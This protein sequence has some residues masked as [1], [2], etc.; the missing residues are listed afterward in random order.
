LLWRLPPFPRC[1]ILISVPSAAAFIIGIVTLNVATLQT[2]TPR[3]SSRPRV[4][5]QVA[6][7]QHLSADQR[8]LD[9]GLLE[10][11]IPPTLPTNEP[12]FFAVTVTDL[13]KPNIRMTFEQYARAQEAPGEFI[14]DHNVPTGGILSLSLNC[15]STLYCQASGDARQA[16]VGAESSGTWSWNITPL[17]SGETLAAITAMT[18][19]GT[20]DV[21]LDRENIPITLEIQEGGW[22]DSLAT[23]WDTTTTF[24]T[25]TAGQ[26]TALGGAVTVMAGGVAWAQRRRARKDKNPSEQT[27]PAEVAPATHRTHSQKRKTSPRRRRHRN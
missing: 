21:V 20:S 24:A 26:I 17:H 15:P 5:P 3:G 23:W 2:V 12:F 14:Y 22:S 25:T 27:T 10:Y 8:A 18:Y 16:I 7:Q 19:D 9:E 6:L 4:A 13:G 11:P 1:F